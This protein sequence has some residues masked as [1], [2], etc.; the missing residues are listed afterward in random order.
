MGGVWERQILTVRIVLISLLDIH[1]T[2]L[3]D[4]SLRTFMVEAE[5]IV[6]SRPLTV[7][8][9]NHL[10]PLT[11]NHLLTLKSKVIL[12]P[13][14][15]FL[16]A[17]TYSKKRWRRVQY[18]IDEFWYRWRKDFFQ[19]L[20]VRQK[21]IRPRKNLQVEDVVIVKDADMPRNRWKLARVAETYPEDD[22]LVRKVKLAMADSTLDDKE[23]ENGLLL[24]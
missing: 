18:L 21:W 22:G 13:P 23:D 3:D 8:N 24:I 14:G 16:R 19:S 20:Q 5:A 6:N 1:G 15:N 4:G 7:E 2:I 11:T 17:D 10:E 9:L 12:P